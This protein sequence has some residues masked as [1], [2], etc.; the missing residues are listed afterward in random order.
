M[1]FWNLHADKVAKFFEEKVVLGL[2]T[3]QVEIQNL[4]F[5]DTQKV[6][7]NIIFDFSQLQLQ[8]N[9]PVLLKLTLSFHE[10]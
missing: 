8:L 1:F 9:C 10:F 4:I 6:C 3:N 7:Q 5:H 2:T